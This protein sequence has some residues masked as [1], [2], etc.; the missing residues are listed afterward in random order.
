MR[1]E[2][3]SRMHNPYD[4]LPYQSSPIEWTAPERLA[5]AS[6]L[7]G[8][9]RLDLEASYRVLELGCADGANLLP[10]AWYRQHASFVGVDGAATQIHVARAHAQELGLSN[11]AFVHADLTTTNACLDGQFDII[12]AHGVFSW[13]PLAARN[14]LL[15]LCARRLAP[16]GLLYFNYNA[17]P[18]W[19]VRGMVREFLLAQTA[20]IVELRAR[21]QEARDVCQRLI[22]AMGGEEH[23]YRRLMLDELHLVRDGEI[24]Y[25]AHE[26]LAPQNHAY[27]RSEMA[28]LLAEYGLVWVAD[29]DFD[30]PWAR[31]DQSFVGWLRDASIVGRSL[32]DTTDL[33]LYRQLC[34]PIITHAPLLRHEPDAP[35]LARLRV[36][37]CL[38]ERPGQAPGSLPIVFDHPTG[39]EV[40]V[41]ETKVADALRRLSPLWPCSVGLGEV[42]TNPLAILDDLRLLHRNGLVQLRYL[43]P[44]GDAGSAEPLHRLEAR[45]GGYR[46]TPLHVRLIQTSDPDGT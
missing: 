43:E 26:Y 38:V 34:S 11:I 45:R 42:F 4:E 32:E 35:D 5:L 41:R 33:L 25:V 36:A 12:V 6:L 44:R 7:H 29:A 28:A 21:A 22:D 9:P 20:E 10:M 46:T 18:G 19:N 3:P 14:A 13:I 16:D 17:K 15:E 27:W 8:G 31:M 37:S 30:Q 23:A 40:E 1:Y 2:S 24:S 39:Y